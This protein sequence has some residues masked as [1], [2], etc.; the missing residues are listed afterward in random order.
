MIDGI[1]PNVFD[2]NFERSRLLMGYGIQILE[3]KCQRADVALKSY[4]E[5]IT[6]MVEQSRNRQMGGG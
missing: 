6:R 2:G 4:Q 5:F 3:L 1:L